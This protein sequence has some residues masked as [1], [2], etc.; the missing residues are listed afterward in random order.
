MQGKTHTILGEVES[1]NSLSGGG[2]GGGITIGEQ[3]G[4]IPQCAQHIFDKKKPNMTVVV[5]YLE[6]YCEQVF[7]LFAPQ[8]NNNNNSN[9]ASECTKLTL[10]KCTHEPGFYA[11]NLCEVAVSSAAELLQ[12]VR[13]GAARRRV[14]ATLQNER[15]SRSHALLSICIRRRV[16]GGGDADSGGGGATAG[17]SNSNDSSTGGRVLQS[18]LNLVDLAG[19][20]RYNVEKGAES[21]NINQS[22][23]TLSIVIQRLSQRQSF[24]N[25]RDS[26]L[27]KLLESSLSGRSKTTVI[28]CVNPT[29][30]NRAETTSTVRFAYQAKSIPIDAKKWAEDQVK[31]VCCVV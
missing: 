24:V 28:A 17:D 11:E 21:L 2:G 20:E 31:T 3:A 1:A 22:L 18:K 8:S 23:T 19:S 15:S 5:S 4:L 12:A 26:E 10:R 13:R 16:G 14:A 7:D 9:N 30:S 27:T 6:V 29:Q 25:F